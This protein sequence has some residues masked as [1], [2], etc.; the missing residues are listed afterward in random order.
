LAG[1]ASQKIEIVLYH[2]TVFFGE[3]QFLEAVFLSRF[4]LEK[5]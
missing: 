4:I 3:C 5:G 1:A 2:F